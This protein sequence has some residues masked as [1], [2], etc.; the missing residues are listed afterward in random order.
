M[1]RYQ[2]HL[3]WS[4]LRVGIVVTCALLV[5][6]ITTLFVGSIKTLFTPQATIYASFTDVKGLRAG[7][8]V[9]F[10]GVNIGSVKSLD[11]NG[12]KI[13][14][15]LG[16]ER[17]ALV[18]IKKDSEASIQTLGLLGDKY[19]D[20]SPG[21]RQADKVK[22]GD[23]IAGLTRAELNEEISQFIG[24]LGNK[25]GSLGRFLDDDMLYR[26]A[27]SAA[28]DIKLFAQT[29]KASEGTINALVKDPTV[30]KNFLRASQSLDTF[31][32]RL[33]VSRGTMH[34]L[35]EDESLYNNVNTA[36]VK[37]NSILDK[38]NNGEGT[39]G[40]LV[41]NRELK[42]EMHAT[43]KEINSLIKDVRDNPKRFFKFSVF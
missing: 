17:S 11:F 20:I 42:E 1:S 23:E 16:I 24:K 14:A 7:A 5:L 36:V 41:G 15:T 18:Y 3:A 12:G 22:S 37:L 33:V 32:Q 35:I 31:T 21:S 27:A 2:Q 43:M 39:V 9:S 34:K 26:D 4:K 25:K 10:A 29:L 28:K 30:Y 19:V 40:S 38:I 8:P 13:T 6:F